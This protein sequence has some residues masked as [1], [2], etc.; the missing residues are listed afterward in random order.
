MFVQLHAATLIEWRR[1]LGAAP[2]GSWPDAAPLHIA[3]GFV[4][5]LTLR[6]MRGEFRMRWVDGRRAFI[7]A[8]AMLAAPGGAG[9]AS[10]GVETYSGDYVVSYLGLTIARSSFSGR[11]ENGRFSVDGSVATAGIAEVVSSV[12]GTA[13][14][15][16][17][18]AGQRTQPASFTMNYAEGRRKQL[19]EL[20]FRDG[21]V[22]S[23]RNTPPLKKRGADWVP[24]T[25]AHLRG[26]TDPLSAGIVKARG[27][28]EVC[29]RTIRLF[30]GEMRLDATLKR[31]PNSS[32]AK[33]YGD[34]VVTCRVTVRPVAGYRKGRHALE[35]LQHQSKIMV[36]F[37]PLGSTGV[38]APVHA[39]IGT[40]I[41]TVTVKALR[42]SQ[43]N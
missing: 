34:G 27:P 28:S 13:S 38:Y 32:A 29:G 8:A 12:K 14:A 15:S 24:V 25:A 36:A 4:D 23:N 42:V 17:G 11:F 26:V 5:F 1:A 39:T 35:Y 3:A 21:T 43:A 41:G 20:G 6:A 9:P 30:D 22:V 31:V 19:T 40:E 7:F 33:A 37:A 10:A 16:G 18:F 2:I